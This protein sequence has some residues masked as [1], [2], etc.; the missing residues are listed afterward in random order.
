MAC[1][2]LCPNPSGCT[3]ENANSRFSF[4]W[5]FGNKK[6]WPCG[7]SCLSTD[8]PPELHGPG[9]DFIH[10]TLLFWEER[11][12]S[13]SSSSPCLEVLPAEN[14]PKAMQRKDGLLKMGKLLVFLSVE[15]KIEGNCLWLFRMSH[16]DWKTGKDAPKAFSPSP[17]LN[18]PGRL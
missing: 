3:Q 2:S 5:S 9:W 12:I 8:H 14:P 15:G 11:E 7:S 10:G 13:K 6:N 16:L 1:A 4:F 18:I 17:I